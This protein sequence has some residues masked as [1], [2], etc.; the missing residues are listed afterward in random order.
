MVGSATT[1]NV[2][3][4]LI[5][6]PIQRMQ[7][8]LNLCTTLRITMQWAAYGNWQY[9]KYTSYVHSVDPGSRFKN[10]R[11]EKAQR[12]VII[13]AMQRRFST[14][15][16]LAHSSTFAPFGCRF[17]TECAQ[18]ASGFH[19]NFKVFFFLFSI[20]WKWL[21]RCHVERARARSLSLICFILETHYC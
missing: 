11:N 13:I 2:L 1:R 3:A 9:G 5:L 19:L 12:L 8:Q 16:F 4:E 10:L 15:F 20:K 6:S 17:K 14:F 7:W 18:I 21:C